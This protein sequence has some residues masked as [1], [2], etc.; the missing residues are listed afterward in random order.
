MSEGTVEKVKVGGL[1]RS[2][3]LPLRGCPGCQHPTAHRVIG[4]VLEEMNMDG[5]CIVAIG[6]GCAA[7][8]A[9]LNLDAV[10]ALRTS[11]S[12]CSTTPT[13]GPPEARSRRPRW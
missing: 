7:A 11:P 10:L 1:Q 4:E 3:W 8:I 6:I 2:Y 12:S 5:E 13:T 9:M